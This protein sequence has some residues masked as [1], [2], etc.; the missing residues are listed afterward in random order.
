MESHKFAT[1]API[2]SDLGGV[3]GNW[4][5]GEC[6]FQVLGR[7]TYCGGSKNHAWHNYV[8]CPR[9]LDSG[10]FWRD[11]ERRDVPWPCSCDMGAEMMEFL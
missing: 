11:G 8:D 7:N 4:S 1:E 9:C 10:V 5:E 3:F 2:D 6:G